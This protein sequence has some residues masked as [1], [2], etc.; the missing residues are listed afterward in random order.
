M[1][2]QGPPLVA[3][4]LS[5][6]VVAACF[7]DWTVTS[8][9]CGSSFIRKDPGAPGRF[10]RSTIAIDVRFL[11]VSRVVMQPMSGRY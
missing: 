9:C 11:R 10:H 8:P 5:T 1:K 7:Q 3:V 2:L 4:V 6:F